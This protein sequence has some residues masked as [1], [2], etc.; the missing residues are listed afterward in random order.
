MDVIFVISFIRIELY[1]ISGTINTMS[2]ISK[3]IVSVHKKLEW[4]KKMKLRLP[5]FY[6]YLC[7]NT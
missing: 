2:M 4:Y 3:N 1:L 6:S 7:L 5:A